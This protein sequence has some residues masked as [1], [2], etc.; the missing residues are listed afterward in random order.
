MPKAMCS[1]VRNDVNL[2]CDWLK[3]HK[4]SDGYV[5]NIGNCVNTAEC[6]TGLKSHDF[7]DLMQRVISVAPLTCSH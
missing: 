3:N 4:F 2:V 6:T 5:S 1:L 7:H